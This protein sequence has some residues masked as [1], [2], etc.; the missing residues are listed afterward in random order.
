MKN[1]I[2]KS[3]LSCLWSYDPKSIK[4]KRDKNTVITQVLNYGLTNDVHWL[5]KT[6]GEDGIRE[7]VSKPSRGVW[8]KHTLNYWCKML[9]IQLSETVYKHAL[10]YNG[11][12]AD[13]NAL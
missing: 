2:P 1:I 9:N 5:H 3:V 4:L 7:V 11:P 13:G 8:L 6:Y 10:R 12:M